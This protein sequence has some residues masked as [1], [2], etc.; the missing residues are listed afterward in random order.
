MKTSLSTRYC[1]NQFYEDAVPPTLGAAFYQHTV[2][3]SGP[4]AYLHLDLWDTAGQEQFR[5]MGPM[6]YREA[7]LYLM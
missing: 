3:L 2:Y 7:S 1:L 5:S 4:G 6:F